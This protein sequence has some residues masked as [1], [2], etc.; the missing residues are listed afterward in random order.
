MNKLI[1]RDCNFKQI[2]TPLYSPNF[3]LNHYNSNVRRRRKNKTHNRTN[4]LW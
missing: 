3:N 4:V 1:W 2:I